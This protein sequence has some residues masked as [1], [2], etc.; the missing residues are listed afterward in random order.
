MT[1]PAKFNNK[2]F[3][4]FMTVF[5][6][7][8]LV[9]TGIV[10]YFSPPGRVA[11]WIEWRF[12]GLTK[13][14]WQAVHTI[15]SFTFIIVAAFHLYFNWV[16]FLSYL[17][18]RVRAGIKMRRE[19]M[20]SSLLVLVMFSLIILEVRPFKS[21]MDFGEDLSNSWSNQQT[22]PPIPHAELLTLPEYAE[23]TNLDL[24]KLLQTFED[25]GIQ[26]IDATATIEELARINRLSPRELIQQVDEYSDK[27][28]AEFLGYGRMT[29]PDI[30]AA[31]KIEEGV[32]IDRLDKTKIQFE[33]T[34]ILKNIAERNDLKPLD[35]VNI[36]KGD[37]ETK[38]EVSL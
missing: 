7:L 13:E 29:I 21:V 23:K 1:H 9:I 34:E 26:G 10:L 35:I 27:I 4:S 6:W 32:A 18:S 12:L 36:I 16:V 2:A 19:L 8:I 33:K 37:G 5:I 22:E 17:K 30:C 25:A 14:G 28:S 24:A 38:L 15:F 31:L 11:H 3:F 20:F